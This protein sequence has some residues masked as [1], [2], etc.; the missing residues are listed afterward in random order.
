MTTDDGY[1]SSDNIGTGNI[2][3]D[4]IAVGRGASATSHHGT[5]VY[6][7]VGQERTNVDPTDRDL[8][9]DIH[10]LLL[11]NPRKGHWRG[12]VHRVDDLRDEVRN[13]YRYQLMIVLGAIIVVIGLLVIIFTSAAAEG[14]QIGVDLW[15]YFVVSAY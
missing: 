1:N 4:G 6:N 15:R 9:R 13:L 7:S 12:L 5:T 3:G 2:D 10:D 11:G 14:A 8:L